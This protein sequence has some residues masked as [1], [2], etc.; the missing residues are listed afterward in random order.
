MTAFFIA[1]IVNLNAYPEQSYRFHKQPDKVFD[2]QSEMIDVRR[3]LPN[4]MVWERKEGRQTQSKEQAT[5][6]D[7]RHSDPRY[8]PAGSYWNE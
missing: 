5:A 8:A 7:N 4:S 6:Y 2:E 1:L 3:Y